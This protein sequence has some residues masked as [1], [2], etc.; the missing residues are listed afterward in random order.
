MQTGPTLI[1][2]DISVSDILDQTQS[3]QSMSISD[4]NSDAHRPQQQRPPSAT[5]HTP[6]HS[7]INA[8]LQ[9]Q[10]QHSPILSTTNARTALKEYY[11]ECDPQVPFSKKHFVTYIDN[12]SGDHVPRFTAFHVSFKT[13]EIFPSGQMN[14]A[15]H[16]KKLGFWWYMKSDKAQFAAAGLALDCFHYRENDTVAETFCGDPL[17]YEASNELTL[18]VLASRGVPSTERNKIQK[19]Q[20]T[21][22]K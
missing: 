17:P 11:D 2:S 12:S 9:L 6:I 5:R 22:R 15:C 16:E 21:A 18:D 19:L 20:D 8:Q 13:G 14:G 3:V 1:P 10:Q 4:N 7:N